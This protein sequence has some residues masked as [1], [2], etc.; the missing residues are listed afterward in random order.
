MVRVQFGYCPATVGTRGNITSISL[1]AKKLLDKG[2][3]NIE[4]FSD[5]AL[6]MLATFNG[7]SNSF[8]KVYGI[9]AYES[10]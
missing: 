8:A 7:I 3:M 9:F 2:L 10:Y 5:F 6:G 1:L 4:H